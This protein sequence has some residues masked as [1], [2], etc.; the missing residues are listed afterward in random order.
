MDDPL[1]YVERSSVF[2]EVFDG[3]YV[4]IR[5]SITVDENCT[6]CA[7]AVEAIQSRS[8]QDGKPRAKRFISNFRVE[9]VSSLP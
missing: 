3:T 2:R 9:N 6:L 5:A 4:G 1:L 8:Y 7:I